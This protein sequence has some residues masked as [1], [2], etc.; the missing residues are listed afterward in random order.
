MKKNI[1]E[2]PL[3]HHF[4]KNQFWNIINEA[5]IRRSQ[6][7]KFLMKCQHFVNFVSKNKIKKTFLLD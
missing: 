7:A 3:Y 2:A 4:L 6:N 1:F 5:L